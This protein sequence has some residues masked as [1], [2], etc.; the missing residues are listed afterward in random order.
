MMA[1][2]LAIKVPMRTILS[3]LFIFLGCVS[4]QA[5]QNAFEIYIEGAYR[6][7]DLKWSIEPDG[8]LVNV[9]QDA[10]WKHMQAPEI[11]GG[12]SMRPFYDTTGYGELANL[13]LELEGGRVI[14]VT[15]KDFYG[16]YIGQA[17]DELF[18]T[19]G[20]RKNSVQGNDFSAS[21]GYDLCINPITLVIPTIGYA[22][23]TRKLKARP[24]NL[25]AI[26]AGAADVA[27]LNL[28]NIHDNNRWSG[29]WVGLYTEIK[30]NCF[31]AL[32]AG[33]EY[34]YARFHGKASWTGTEV[35]DDATYVLTES[36]VH[37]R[38]YINVFVGRAAVH[39]TFDDSWKVTVGGLYEY[40]HKTKG[41]DH[42]RTT[43]SYFDAD[44][45]TAIT[46]TRINADGSLTWQSFAATISLNYI[47]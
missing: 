10:H 34:H 22:T 24:D 18:A 35:F 16:T 37:Q 23:E 9:F 43:A 27:L 4:L 39:Y 2:I 19:N 13:Y 14:S 44:G 38:G 17:P 5:Y 41:S 29:P 42:V 40:F 3:T 46:N 28:S 1:L 12:V 8:E 32:V 25:L 45:L 26:S 11:R 31:W 33:G 21:L 6:C 30:P 7:D 15:G 20:K 47:F 36:K